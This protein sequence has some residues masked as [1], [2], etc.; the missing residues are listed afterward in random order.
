MHTLHK[1]GSILMEQ[2]TGVVHL[3]AA[4]TWEGKQKTVRITVLEDGVTK[5]TPTQKKIFL[6]LCFRMHIS[7]IPEGAPV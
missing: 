2:A 7:H 5:R 1:V 4:P 6:K 3:G